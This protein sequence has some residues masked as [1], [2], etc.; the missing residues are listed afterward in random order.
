[1][2]SYRQSFEQICRNDE[3]ENQ[4]MT[5]VKILAIGNSFSQDATHYLHQIAMAGGIDTKVVN[6]YIGGCSIERHWQNIEQNAK[7][8]LYER[9]GKSTRKY[10]SIKDALSF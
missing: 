8:Y 7:L 3:K 9:D 5:Q 6:L 10:V 1:M 4:I 2:E